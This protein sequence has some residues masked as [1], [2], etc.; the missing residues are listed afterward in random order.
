MADI[1]SIVR[2]QETCYRTITRALGGEPG[3]QIQYHL[4]PT[5][6]AVGI[7]YG[8]NE[9][10]N[11]FTRVPD[12]IH[13][14]YNTETQ[15]IGFHEDAHLISYSLFGRPKSTFIREGLAMH[16]DQNWHGYPNTAW[17][18]AY[19]DQLP[20]FSVSGISGNRDFGSWANNITYPMCGAFCSYLIGVYGMQRFLRAYSMI[21]ETAATCVATEYRSTIQC[22]E[23]ELREYLGS[24]RYSA[25]IK[26][27]IAAMIERME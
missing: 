5:A 14:V 21:D 2:T 24:L 25:E 9:P 22:V 15:C 13:A 3:F 26:D 17:A 1:D 6:E 11:G 4:Y 18:V 10:G 7:A 20:D 27:R 8:D 19:Y 12:E 23:K 16:F